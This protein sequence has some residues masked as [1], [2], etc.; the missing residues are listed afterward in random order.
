MIANANQDL[1]DLLV[2]VSYCGIIKETIENRDLQCNELIHFSQNFITEFLI[3][4][5]PVIRI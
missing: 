4:N 5:N 3:L 1:L 2:K